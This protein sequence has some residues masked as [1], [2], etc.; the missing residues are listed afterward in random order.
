[1]AANDRC[2]MVMTT[3]LVSYFLNS[4][5][6]NEFYVLWNLCHRH[7]LYEDYMQYI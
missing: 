7:D 4:Y 1:M 5:D 3:Q 6:F 2:H